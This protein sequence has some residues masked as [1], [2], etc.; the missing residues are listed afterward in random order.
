MVESS[1][2]FCRA[3]TTLVTSFC[4]P[5]NAP[6][7]RPSRASRWP[8]AASCRRLIFKAARCLRRCSPLLAD[9][10]PAVLDV[11][12]KSG[13]LEL[14]GEQNAFPASPRVLEPEQQAWAAAQQWLKQR[15]APDE[16]SGS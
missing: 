10:N 5:A 7:W 14:I 8:P 12:R 4:A 15:S 9:V 11:L 16:G 1:R 6:I 3:A 13:A 2:S